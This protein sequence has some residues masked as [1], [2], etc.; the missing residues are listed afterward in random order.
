M[1]KVPNSAQKILAAEVV[2]FVHGEQGLK[3]ALSATEGV[4]G[5]LTGETLKTHAKDMPNVTLSRNEVVGMKFVDLIS[6]L[7]LV[8]SKS[9][10]TRLIKNGG[11]YVN[12]DRV[13]D[14]GYLISES[15]L[16]DGMYLLISAGKKNKVLIILS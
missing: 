1:S 15:E 12:Q 16:I 3:S 10:A 6:Q 7:G 5:P 9:E 4:Q 14:V 2:R 11:A 8:S 13:T